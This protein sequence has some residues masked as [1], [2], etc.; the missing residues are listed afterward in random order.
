MPQTA[1]EFDTGMDF[2]G[3]HTWRGVPFEK[4]VESGLAA[5][6]EDARERKA[7]EIKEEEAAKKMDAQRNTEMRALRAELAAA[8][9]KLD[10]ATAE[11]SALREELAAARAEIAAATAAAERAEAEAAA[12]RAE[13]ARLRKDGVARVAAFKEYR[14][15]RE[16]FKGYERTR[17]KRRE[18][19][20]GEVLE[21]FEANGRP[22]YGPKGRR[23][24]VGAFLKEEGAWE[25]MG[26]PDAEEFERRR[27]EERRAHRGA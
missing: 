5:L 4:M 9:A 27:R 1:I 23:I 13:N 18:A 21:D 25:R 12:L 11:R 7:R 14:E 15:R 16:A 19:I 17:A 26:C 6:L 3:F 10:A 24:T 22:V 20:A 2:Q 8:N